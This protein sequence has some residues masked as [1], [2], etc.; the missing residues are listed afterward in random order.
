MDEYTPGMRCQWMYV[1]DVQCPD[2]ATH[3]IDVGADEIGHG[4]VCR[5]HKKHFEDLRER[6]HRLE[7]VVLETIDSYIVRKTEEGLLGKGKGWVQE[8]SPFDGDTLDSTLGDFS[9]G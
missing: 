1:G 8:P 4:F 5:A 3:H 7:M 6:N 2:L 9:H